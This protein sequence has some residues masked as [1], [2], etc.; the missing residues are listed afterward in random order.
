MRRQNLSYLEV[1][2]ILLFSDAHYTPIHT[3]HTLNHFAKYALTFTFTI[4]IHTPIA[5]TTDPDTDAL[6]KSLVRNIP[7]LR[8]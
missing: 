8:I 7:G 5:T 1:I 3:T 4:P 6:A 2:Y